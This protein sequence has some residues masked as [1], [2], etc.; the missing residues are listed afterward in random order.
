MPAS[1]TLGTTALRYGLLLGLAFCAYTTLL[2][3]TR[4]DTTYLRIGQHLDVAVLVLPLTFTFLAVR[5]EARRRSLTIGRRVL[6]GLLVTLVANLV[7]WPFLYCYHHVINPAWFSYVEALRV[8]ELRAAGVTATEQAKQL[9]QLRA[10]SSDR[11]SL[12]SA[13]V[14]GVGILGPVFGLL[15]WPFVK[16]PTDVAAAD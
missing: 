8:Q 15:T 16:T 12:I 2:W 10:G 14:M 5:A 7:Y 11:R 4:L 3:L 1:Q 6:L 13:L 9:A